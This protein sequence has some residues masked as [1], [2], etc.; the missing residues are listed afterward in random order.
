MPHDRRVGGVGEFW[1]VMNTRFIHQDR[2][3]LRVDPDVLVPLA[4]GMSGK[5]PRAHHGDFFQWGLFQ[6]REELERY[7]TK[8]NQFDG[9]KSVFRAGAA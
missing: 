8:L 1:G 5:G 7:P 9:G 6:L 2:G 3:C 4:A